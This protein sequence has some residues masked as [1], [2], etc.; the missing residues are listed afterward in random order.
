MSFIAK[1]PSVDSLKIEASNRIPKFAFEYLVGGVNKEINL[2]KNKSDIQ[3]VELMPEYLSTYRSPKL[4]TTIFGQ[5]YDLPFGIAPI[6]LQGLI[7][8]NS[9]E[10]LA[11][12]AAKS[13]TPFILSTVSTSS[14]EHIGEI[15]QG[16]FWFQLYHPAKQIVRDDLLKRAQESGCNV[17]VALAD[18]PSFGIRY[19]DIRNGL[20]MPPRMSIRNIFQIIS[21]PIW[22]FKT[23]QYGL[24]GFATLKPYMPKALNLSQ[25]GHFMNDTFDGRLNENKI[26]ALRDSWPGKLV[27]KGIVNE[28]DAEKAIRLGADGIIVSNHGGRQLDAGESS[29][30]SMIRLVG[31]YKNQITMMM[32]G[33]I[34]SGPDI[35]RCLACGAQ[36]TFMGRPFMYAVGALGKR[37]GSHAM[38]MFKM[39]LSQI[40]EQLGCE[41]IEELKDHLIR[42]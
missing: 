36:F 27:I 34:R 23:L 15:T 4:S 14:I 5:K 21:K 25:L 37:G 31:R 8:P 28:E 7:W 16:K 35:A 40:M 1:Y 10:I 41:K 20:A 30:K 38:A 24:P 42:C 3:N 9:P 26:K 11:Q 32:D 6:G 29:L 19:K 12:S 33:G 22:A 13:N 39:Q 17:L 18:T 2:A